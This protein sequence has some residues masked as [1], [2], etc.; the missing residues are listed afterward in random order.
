[1]FDDFL[2]ETNNKK[3]SNQPVTKYYSKVKWWGGGVGCNIYIV[4]K[5]T[6]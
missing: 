2:R 3:E 1:L 6:K 4:Q 5:Y